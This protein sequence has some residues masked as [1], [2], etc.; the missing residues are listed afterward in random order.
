M[1][2]L[3]SVAKALEMV[4]GLDPG[5]D[6]LEKLEGGL[7]NRTY[8]VS[9]GNTTCVLRLDAPHSDVVRSNRLNELSILTEAAK[10]GLAPHV[11]FSNVEFGILVT[12]YLPGLIWCESDLRVTENLEKL[13]DLLRSVHGLPVCGFRQDML[14]IAV[15][16]QKYFEKHPELNAF[17][18]KCIDIIRSIASSDTITCCHNDV[19]AAN[20]VESTRLQLID[21]EFAADYDPFFD[22][23]SVIGFHNLGDKHAN[24]LLSAY[25]G[26]DN[27][28]SQQK[29]KQ[30]LRIYY[31]VYWLWLATRQV[32]SPK[33]WQVRRLGELQ[34]RII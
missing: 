23:A 1:T 15:S 32:V 24:I 30:Q 11:I 3:I 34:K 31:V 21:W 5:V 9:Q 17:A 25:T 20:V 33:N 14:E 22:L 28:T 4:P 26:G 27:G 13:A 2:S 7:T 16:Y 6:T 8:Y 10:V 29:L 12:E 18:I 19:V